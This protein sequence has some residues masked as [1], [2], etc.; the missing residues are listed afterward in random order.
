M[1]MTMAVGFGILIGVVVAIAAILGVCFHSPF[2][3]RVRALISVSIALAVALA[4]IFACWWSFCTEQGKRAYKD[5]VS[6]TAGG[7]PRTLRVYDMNGDLIESYTGRFDMD[8]N[9]NEQPIIFDDENGKR[10]IIYCM[11]GTV[12]IDEN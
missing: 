12:I 6:N 7:L 9:N 10:H 5:Q 8:S 1:T 2:A 4:V 3:P 11:T